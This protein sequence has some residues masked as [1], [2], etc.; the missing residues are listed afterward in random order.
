MFFS[1]LC[2]IISFIFFINRWWIFLMIITFLFVWN[3]Q[4]KLDHFYTLNYDLI[5]HWSYLQATCRQFLSFPYKLSLVFGF[6]KLW[7]KIESTGS[8][9]FWNF[10]F[11]FRKLTS[12][13]LHS[14]WFDGN[15]CFLSFYFSSKLCKGV[16]SGSINVKNPM[17]PVLG[18][19]IQFCEKQSTIDLVGCCFIKNLYKNF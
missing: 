19:T 9:T 6:R 5:K 14:T 7:I 12:Y 11:E 13:P 2:W 4:N 3:N 18:S 16:I 10:Y 1:F 15:F 17:P 8:P